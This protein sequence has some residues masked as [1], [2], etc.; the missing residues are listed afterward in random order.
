MTAA[1]T[2]YQTTIR[3]ADA[4]AKSFGAAEAKFNEGVGSV[5][6]YLIAKNNADRANSNLI[7]SRY[8]YLLR[9]KVID[10]YMGRGVWDNQ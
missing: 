1:R 4:F 9:K 7:I 8:D 6:D 5:V 2:R 3:Q 10:Y